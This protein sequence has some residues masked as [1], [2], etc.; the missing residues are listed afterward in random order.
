MA[1][2][3]VILNG[4]TEIDLTGDTATADEV[5]DGETFHLADGT[6][7][8]GTYSG[9][10][11]TIAFESDVNFYDYDGTVVYSYTASEFANLS[12]LP[13]NPTHTGLT[14]QGWNWTLSD[15]KTYVSTYGK[16][17]IGQMYVTSDNKTRLY[18]TLVDGRLSPY[19]G[20]G[21]NGTADVDWGDGST[22]STVTGTSKT[23][24]QFIQHVYSNPG[25][26]V[27]VISGSIGFQTYGCIFSYNGAASAT[28]KYTACIN[29]IELGGNVSIGA[30]A[31]RWCTHMETITLP[32]TITTFGA[33]AFQNCSSLKHCTVPSGTTTAPAFYYNYS[34][35]TVS[36][37]KS[38]TTIPQYFGYDC[39]GFRHITLPPNISVIANGSAFANCES[40]SYATLPNG[41]TKIS[42]SIFFSQCK[43]LLTVTI[44]SLVT[45]LSGQTFNNCLSLGSIH[46]KPVSPPTAVS[47]TFQNMPTD[48]I[49]YV[50]TGSLSAYT[51]AQ[52][53]PDSSTYT[54][55][56]E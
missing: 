33:N 6:Q 8:T 42:G 13:A 36:L 20:F 29:R 25:D 28:P 43:S 9:G 56:E 47:S 34:L 51:S 21:V 37:P 16:L 35:K 55:I 12:A 10:G 50:P 2:S 46:F 48:C 41:L 23:T 49:L 38:I 15:A 17:D 52:Y 3:K 4:I 27:I 32:N 45:Q 39:Y 53:Y 1:V 26:Y 18:V 54:Y 30:T 19:L 40:L 31:F 24:N 44:P 11:T 14:S 5:L 22:H 7:G